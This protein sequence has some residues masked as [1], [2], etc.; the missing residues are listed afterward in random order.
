[1]LTLSQSM[2]FSL[3]N[4]A[5]HLENYSKPQLQRYVIRI[6]WMVS[7]PPTPP[8]SPPLSTPMSFWFQGRAAPSQDSADPAAPTPTR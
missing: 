5:R 4:I 6:Q 7:L 8:P 1:M 3:W 2:P